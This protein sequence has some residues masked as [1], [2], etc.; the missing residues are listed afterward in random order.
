MRTKSVFGFTT[1]D[2]GRAVVPSGKKQG[3]YI[4]RVA[5]R[6][7]G[8]FNLQTITGVIQGIS[9][10]H[11]HLL[12]RGN[13]YGYQLQKFTKGSAEKKEIAGGFARAT[14]SITGLNAGVSR[15]I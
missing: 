5:V 10:K 9:Y 7:S 13:G 1:G 11:C 3:T 14:L 6:A 2:M 15:V 12:Q 4:A 8:F